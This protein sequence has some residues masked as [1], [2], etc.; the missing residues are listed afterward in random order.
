VRCPHLQQQQGEAVVQEG[1]QQ[2]GEQPLQVGGHAT[3]VPEYGCGLVAPD[4]G[5]QHGPC[6]AMQLI[7]CLPSCYALNSA[8]AVAGDVLADL[9]VMNDMHNCKHPFK[10]SCQSHRVMPEPS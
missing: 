6:P 10:A 5:V 1:Q 2:L 3:T 4:D 9:K 8:G 7:P